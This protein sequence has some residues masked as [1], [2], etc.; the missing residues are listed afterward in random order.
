MDV[1]FLNP[2]SCFNVNQ[3]GLQVECIQDEDNR[4]QITTSL[5]VTYPFTKLNNS[6]EVA[7]LCRTQE[8][9]N[10][11]TIASISIAIQGNQFVNCCVYLIYCI[12]TDTFVATFS[13]FYLKVLFIYTFNIV[14][15][16][17]SFF[18]NS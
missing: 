10:I 17:V 11:Q 15:G 3:S 6:V 5:S 9:Q 18:V 14:I 8:N 4:D 7:L 16:S 2:L 13:F 12:I 1:S